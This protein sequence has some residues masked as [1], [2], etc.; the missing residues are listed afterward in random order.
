MEHKS[1]RRTTFRPSGSE[2]FTGSVWNSRLTEG[3][4]G[5]TMIAV[6]FAPGARS[7]WHS[8]PRG[9]VLYVVSGAGLVQT[10]DGSTIEISAGDVVHA[11]PGE[12][13]WHG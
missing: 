3:E 9:Q 6:Q 8:H 1:S 11:P 12:L 5:L 7:D 10:E 13:H 4:G 2:H